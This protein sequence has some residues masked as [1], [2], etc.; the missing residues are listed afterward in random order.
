MLASFAWIAVCVCSLK[1]ATLLTQ[2]W[3]CGCLHPSGEHQPST[4][5][6][7]KTRG[8]VSVF[9]AVRMCSFI[10]LGKNWHFPEAC[11]PPCDLKSSTQANRLVSVIQVWSLKSF[12]S[13]HRNN[14]FQYLFSSSLTAACLAE[15]ENRG[16]GCYYCFWITKRIHIIWLPSWRIYLYRNLSSISLKDISITA[17]L[18]LK[19]WPLMLFNITIVL[20]CFFSSCWC[21]TKLSCGWILIKYLNAKWKEDKDCHVFE[22]L[23]RLTLTFECSTVFFF[24]S[25]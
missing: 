3:N 20:F 23:Y 11:W 9:T 1:Q 7:F 18:K 19:S 6:R 17:H 14:I 8:S 4:E 13:H 5:D 24:F 22:R 16:A 25:P 10:H 15:N 2:K 21:S 12:H